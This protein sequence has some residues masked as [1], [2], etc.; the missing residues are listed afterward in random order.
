MPHRSGPGNQGLVHG[1]DERTSV[2]GLRFGIRA[3]YEIVRKLVAE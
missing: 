3:M 2:D 1:V